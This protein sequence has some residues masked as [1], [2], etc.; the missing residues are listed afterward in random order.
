MTMTLC[1][2]LDTALFVRMC[3]V[4]VARLD[5][6]LFPMWS[7]SMMILVHCTGFWPTINELVNSLLIFLIK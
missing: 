1:G 6:V 2:N 4:W 3:F 5:V 7:C